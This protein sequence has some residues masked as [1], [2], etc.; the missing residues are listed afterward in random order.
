MA[1]LAVILAMAAIHPLALPS[2]D[3]TAGAG[4]VGFTGFAGY[5]S[6]MRSK[7]ALLIEDFPAWTITYGADPMAWAAVRRNGTEIR[8]LVALDLDQLREKIA[9][10]EQE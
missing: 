6:T 2:G 10:V 5:G 1:G 9:A 7:L 8:V 4:F 3:R